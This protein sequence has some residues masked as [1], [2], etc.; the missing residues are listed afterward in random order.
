MIN[1]S[2]GWHGCTFDGAERD[3][4]SSVLASYVRACLG[5]SGSIMR[6]ALVVGTVAFSRTRSGICQ[7]LARRS[8]FLSVLERLVES[9]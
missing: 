4:V 9:C 6:T 3:W 8:K 2:R 1:L 7:A 5:E